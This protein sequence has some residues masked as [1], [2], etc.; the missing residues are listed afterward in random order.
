MLPI[1]VEEGMT[2][3]EALNTAFMVAANDLNYNWAERLGSI[4]T[5]K[6]ADII[7]VSGDP[8]Q[9]I[10][11]MMNVG[12]VMRGGVVIRNDLMTGHPGILAPRMR[13]QSVAAGSADDR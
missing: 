9:N 6:L 1:F 11:E 12:F 5:G 2:E 8:L 10:S 7:A 4:E 13:V 3:A